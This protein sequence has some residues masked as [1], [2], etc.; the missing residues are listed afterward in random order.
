M[1]TY[2]GRWDCPECGQKGVRGGSR[3]CTNCGAERRKDVVFYLPEDALVVTDEKQIAEAKAGED[4]Y[5]VY[6][7]SGNSNAKNIC[8]LCGAKRGAE[9]EDDDFWKRQA[10]GPGINV[11]TR[12]P[13][14]IAPMHFDDPH[15]SSRIPIWRNRKMWLVGALAGAAF[16]IAISLYAL[17][18]TK[19]V[20]LTV[21][22]F[23]WKR[24]ISVESYQTV[25]EEDWD[26]PAGGREK[27]HWREVHHYDRVLDHYVTKTERVCQQIQSGTE[28][29]VCGKRNLGN[30][31]FED[32]YCERP[33][34]REDCR[35][36]T[37]SE[38][39]YRDEPVY[40]TKYRYEIERWKHDRTEQ[41]SGA[42]Q[43]PQWPSVTAKPFP[44]ERESGRTEKYKVLFK[45]KDNKSYA[46]AFS[47]PEWKMFRTGETVIGRINSLGLRKVLKSEKQ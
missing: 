42:D 4:W 29:Y 12:R 31:Y 9:A 17:L 10:A 18:K 16:L 43:K 26:V 45:D 20:V 14:V 13:V 34:Y 46:Y 25:T 27:D 11:R 22:G 40:R 35:N 28:R 19:S 39:V 6:C 21:T 24:T 1:A 33:T 2:E 44:P 47:L 41:A 37:R 30:G 15:V 32:K 3:V 36:E 38:P 8:Q 5:C 23:D 7:K